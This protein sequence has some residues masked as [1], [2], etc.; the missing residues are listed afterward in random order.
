MDR[1]RR[2]T[3]LHDSSVTAVED[4]AGALLASGLSVSIL[5]V[6]D[7]LDALAAG[8]RGRNPELVFNLVE[9]FAGTPRLA[10][11]IAAAL[12]LLGLPYTGAGPPGLYLAADAE[13]A[14]R[15]LVSYGVPD[16]HGEAPSV[17]VAVLGNDR[18]AVFPPNE[19]LAP[20]LAAAFAALRLRDYAILDLGAGPSPGIVRAE[21]NPGLGRDEPF[22]R[23]AATAGL[24]YQDLILSIADEAWARHKEIAG[25][26]K[27]A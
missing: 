14:H 11:D 19:P 13:L 18:L 24:A 8:L 4:V 6:N 5:E 9:R 2:I 22:A 20:L 10:P 23:A 25:A 21:P 26:V 7:D 27:T 1:D 3:I 16:A 15:L 17:R 12:D